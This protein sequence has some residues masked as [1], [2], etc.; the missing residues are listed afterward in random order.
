MTIQDV[1][2]SQYLFQQ[3]HLETKPI[4]MTKG[5]QKNAINKIQIKGIQIRKEEVKVVL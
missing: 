1:T 5:L 4:H 3:E 2:P